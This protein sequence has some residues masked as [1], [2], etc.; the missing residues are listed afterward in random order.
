MNKIVFSVIG[1]IGC[2][3]TLY[4]ME[5]MSALEKN[6]M[7]LEHIF[8][9]DKMMID[10]II[11]NKPDEVLYL[12]D[13][14]MIEN[15][16]KP[17]NDIVELAAI[18]ALMTGDYRIPRLLLERG[19]KL[20]AHREY[21]SGGTLMHGMV[22]KSFRDWRHAIK[23]CGIEGAIN[24][25]KDHINFLK[26][27]GIDINMPDFN[28]V[29]PLLLLIQ[30]GGS[31]TLARLFIEQ[32]N[33]DVAL[34]DKFGWTLLHALMDSIPNFE[35]ELG[36]FVQLVLDQGA[37]VNVQ[38]AIGRTP[39]HIAAQYSRG[40]NFIRILITHGADVDKKDQRGETALDYAQKYNFRDIVQFLQ[41]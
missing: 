32:C 10:A 15:L 16:H 34:S 40:L 31:F 1:V 3:I 5:H 38:D 9:P 20:T 29:T 12:L 36:G 24:I 33:A 25:Y 35:D 18:N 17:Q 14:T 6:L 28:G 21:F 8:N 4:P 26:E 13:Q 30:G 41:K 19:V 27:A 2:H 23:K 22:H 7:Q 39:L 37:D 11:R